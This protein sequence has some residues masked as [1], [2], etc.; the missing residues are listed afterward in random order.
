MTY[1]NEETQLNEIRKS[2]HKQNEK[3]NRKTEIIKKYQNEIL[4]LKNSMNK[5]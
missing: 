1:K 4:K 2:I 5:M 3:F